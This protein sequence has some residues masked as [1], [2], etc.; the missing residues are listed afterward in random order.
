MSFLGKNVLLSCGFCDNISVVISQNKLRKVIIVLGKHNRILTAGL[1]SDEMESRLRECGYEV[2]SAHDG[3]SAL[4]AAASVNPDLI[5]V[6]AEMPDM[7][8]AKFM[9]K[10]LKWC[11]ARV[12]VVYQKRLRSLSAEPLKRGAVD[13]IAAPFSLS[14]LLLRVKHALEITGSGTYL[15]N[16]RCCVGDLVVDYDEY[17]VYLGG[18][19]VSLTR[20]EYKLV[21]F[22]SK[23]AGSVLPHEE[24][25]RVIWGPNNTGG[26]T[27]L[28]VHIANIRRK[29]G[30]S[31]ASPRYIQTV[32]GT[33]Y[34]MPS[35][36]EFTRLEK[37]K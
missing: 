8:C 28:R 20:S 21:S 11:A 3:R 18:E 35:T 19:C 16:S 33:G 22:L 24:L 14:E 26:G 2:L 31:H 17:R 36:V 4:I 7:S 12:I 15:P 34:M 9:E 37:N 27:A 30:E 23:S 5:I 32:S 13:F 6:G 29:L 1:D 25:Q 10:L